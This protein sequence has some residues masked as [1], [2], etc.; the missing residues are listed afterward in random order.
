MFDLIAHLEEK[1][2]EVI[3]FSIKSKKNIPTKYEK[4]FAEPLGGQDEAYFDDLKKTPK[5]ALSVLSRLFYSFHVKKRLE[6]LLKKI[7]PDV[8][9]I[10]LHYNKLSPSV[11]DACKKYNLPVYVRLSDYFLVCPTPTLSNG[12]G[13]LCEACIEKN[14]L[15][16]VSNK[17]I[18]DSYVAST[19]KAFAII[20]Q[21]KVLRI[22]D[23]VDK[24]I[25]TNNFMQ[26]K[27][28]EKGYSK[29]KLEVIP[30]FKEMPYRN[31][32]TLKQKHQYVLYFGRFGKEKAIDTLVYAYLKS[33]LYKQN[34]YLYLLGGSK[35]E[36][37]LKLDSKQEKI[38]N[39]HC[40][41]FG[42]MDKEEVNK[43]ISNALYVVQPSRIYENLPNSILEAF[44][45]NKVVITANIGSLQYMVPKEVGLLYEFENSDDLASKMLLMAK[46]DVRNELERNIPKH[47][48]QYSIE[49]HYKKLISIFKD[50]K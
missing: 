7:K 35:N 13:E 36:L 24:F 4:Y 1:G 25:C 9:Y 44:S 3:P 20:F 33:D 18:K 16:C 43:Y 46:D 29:N 10:L 17:C 48:K 14:F 40:K 42:F 47:F 12:K 39:T 30:T 50:L 34:I 19:L 23:K 5:M 11:I 22:Y 37:Q 8:A 31:Y 41:I 45:F 21:T 32:T 28:A 49:K 27:M 38:F 15:Q 2:H 26:S 6:V